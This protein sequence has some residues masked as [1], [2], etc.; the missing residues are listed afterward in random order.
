MPRDPTYYLLS[1]Y[2]GGP[3]CPIMDTISKQYASVGAANMTIL[4]PLLKEL[5]NI[6][7]E[8]P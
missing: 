8:L 4:D 5:K 1:I 3:L 7:P 6:F 2:G